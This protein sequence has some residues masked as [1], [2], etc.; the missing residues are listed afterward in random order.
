LSTF[1]Q[2]SRSIEPLAG[3]R[4]ALGIR[5][6]G[7]DLSLQVE[8]TAAQDNGRRVGRLG[9]HSK[10]AIS[11]PQSMVRHSALGPGESLAMG[12]RKAWQM[13]ALQATVLWRMLQGHV[14]LKNLSGPLGIAEQAGESAQ[15]GVLSF[16]YFLALISLS[17]GSLNLLPVP[18]LDGGQIV[19]Q[20]VEWFKGSPLSERAQVLGQQLGIGV[21]VLLMGLAL[22]QDIL[23][24][25][26]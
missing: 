12:A 22:F 17:L 15:S 25:F 8:V 10:A 26:G 14:S 13:T 23:R 1:E 20:V 18:I 11:M 4:V 9:I 6:A 16:G 21:L 3:S 7:Q 24:Q 5:R 19:Y 2:L